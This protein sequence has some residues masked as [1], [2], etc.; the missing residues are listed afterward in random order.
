MTQHNSIFTRLI[1]LGGGLLLGGLAILALL[2]VAAH[3]TLAA[4]L[5]LIAVMAALI[6]AMLAA[7]YAGFVR[8]L[9]S[10]TAQLNTM[11]RTGELS[12]AFDRATGAE[13]GHITMALGG[14][15]SQV[16]ACINQTQSVIQSL[17]KGA[18]DARIRGDFKG[19]MARVQ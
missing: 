5:T 10:L 13:I 14:V 2:P 7:T 1:L 17:E 3:L 8:P 19:D 16:S 11:Q 18:F 6:G 4:W 12:A 9:A 15:L